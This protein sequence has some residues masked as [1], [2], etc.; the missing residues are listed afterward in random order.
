MKSV[1]GIPSRLPHKLYKKVKWQDEYGAV[2]WSRTPA[3][4]TDAEVVS[5]ELHDAIGDHAPV[6]DIDV[7]IGI[8]PSSTPGHCH[9]YIDVRMSWRQYKRMLKA[10]AAAGVLEEGYV[11]ASI[12]RRHTAVRVPWLKK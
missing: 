11:K 9:L 2:G 7:P 1:I 5:S 12:R 4:L 10:M 6:L 3:V 8:V